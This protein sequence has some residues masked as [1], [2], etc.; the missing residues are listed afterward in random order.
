MASVARY[1]GLVERLEREAQQAPGRYKFKLAL[2][3][4]LGFAVLGGTVLLAL[5]M[6][7]GLVVALL[8]ISP[9]LLLKLI[10]VIWIPVAFGWFVLKALWVKFEPPEGYV[11]GA[12]EAPALRAEIERLRE[13]TGAPPLKQILIDPNLNAGA[14]SVP[15]LMGLLGHTHYLVLGLPLMQLL[16][17]EQFAAVVA[18]EFGHFGGGHGRFS[19]WIYRV[20]ASWCRFLG[21]L[22]QR[23][24]RMGAVFLRFFNWY[25]PY[26]DAYSFVLAR[27]QEYDA[28][29]TAARVTGAPAMAQALQRVGL[30]GLR[31]QR[32]FWAGVERSVTAQPAPPQAL[33][34]DMAGSFAA[35]N[36]DEPARLDELLNEQPGLDDTHPTLAQRLQAL[37]QTPAAVPAPAQTAAQA[38]L[39]PLQATL[40]ERFSRQW[41]EQVAESWRQRHDA[42]GQDQAR[43]SELEARV[44]A[45]AGAELGEYAMLV[46]R[47]REEADAVPLYRAALAERPDDALTRARL[48]AKLLDREDAEGV[49]HLERA[50]ALDPDLAEQALPMLMGHHR[51]V[52]DEAAFE[53]AVQR[54]TALYQRRDGALLAREQVD[55]KKDRLLEHGLGADDLRGAVAG[56]QAS[57]KVKQAWIVRKQ[58]EGDDSGIPHYL[59]LLELRGVAWTEGGMLQQVLD[60]LELP[61]S[62]VVLH[63]SS[64][65]ALAKRIKAVPGARVYVRG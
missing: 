48:G 17:R 43:L 33:Y 60:G 6:S 62:V 13:Q 65:R 42:H 31:L 2:L 23:R 19:G 27:A 37:G 22:S 46:D 50:L 29:A 51:R 38:L 30:G 55:A 8:A 36:S 39:G 52:G 56:L 24:S 34:R 9:V 54:L 26:F 45:L 5:G 53:A 3:A 59:V 20:R 58:I 21:E 40:E 16:S 63:A 35:V 32:D 10:K 1:R 4:G 41:R 18:H 25:A 11:L 47:L 28:D 15:R 61:G 7:V 44:D 12:D 49:E 14:A 64:H 57:G